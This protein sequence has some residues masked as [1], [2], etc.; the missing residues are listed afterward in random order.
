MCKEN[1][2]G[3]YKGV[4]NVNPEEWIRFQREKIE[5]EEGT[6]DKTLSFTCSFFP[7]WRTTS[8][9]SLFTCPKDYFPL[10]EPRLIN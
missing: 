8:S 5:E 2:L 7:A 4:L 9:F 10:K 6:S 3:Q 1:T